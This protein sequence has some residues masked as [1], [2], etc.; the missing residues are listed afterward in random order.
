MKSAAFDTYRYIREVILEFQHETPPYISYIQYM[1][2]EPELVYNLDTSCLD[3]NGD[4]SQSKTKKAK[5]VSYVV[6]LLSLP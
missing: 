3:D 4:I 2:D 5:S 1:A 6:L